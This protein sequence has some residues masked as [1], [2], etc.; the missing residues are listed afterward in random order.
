MIRR[1]FPFLLL[2][3]CAGCGDAELECPP[4]A[5][6]GALTAGAAGV[7]LHRVILETGGED[8]E[9]VA[10][11]RGCADSCGPDHRAVL[12]CFEAGQR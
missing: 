7:A 11:L 8:P 12:A 4:L 10:L 9:R 3:L 6:A 5:T 1:A 2:L